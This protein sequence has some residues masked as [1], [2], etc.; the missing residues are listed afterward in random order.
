MVRIVNVH[1]VDKEAFYSNNFE[2][3][4]NEEK[5]MA[6]VVTSLTCV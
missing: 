3:V 5:V 4:D 6:V 2:Y 1:Y